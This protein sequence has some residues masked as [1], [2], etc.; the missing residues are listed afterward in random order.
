M[1]KVNR[2]PV[3]KD[4]IDNVFVLINT[5]LEMR[6]KQKGDGILLSSH[7]LLGIITEEYNELIDAIHIKNI[8]GMMPEEMYKYKKGEVFEELADIAVACVFGMACL[9]DMDWI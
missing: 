6:L 2:K 9:N 7:E 8:V 4:V 5:K 3:N 1:S